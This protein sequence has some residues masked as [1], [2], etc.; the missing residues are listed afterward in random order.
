M[1]LYDCEKSH[2]ALQR[3]TP[4][5]FENEYCIACGKISYESNDNKQTPVLSKDNI[6]NKSVLAIKHKSN[7][8]VKVI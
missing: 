7:K 3:K 5:Q 4:I 6:S 1:Q 2:I 8:T